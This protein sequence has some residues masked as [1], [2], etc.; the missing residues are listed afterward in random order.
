MIGVELFSGVGGMSLGAKKAGIE[1]KL[2]V[3]INSKAASTFK[4]NHK[5]TQVLNIDITDLEKINVEETGRQKVL[6]GGPP[7]QGFSLSN[8][9]TRNI[10]NPKNWLFKEFVRLAKQWKPDW[11]VVEN[12]SGILKTEKG[13]FFN[14]IINEFSSLGYKCNYKVL[15]SSNFGVP[16]KRER[17]FIVGSL[18]GINFDFPE[19]NN[20]KKI[21]VEEAIFDL[22]FLENGTSNYKLKYRCSPISDYAKELRKSSK[23]SFNNCVTKNDK[24]VIDRYMCVPQGG[25]WENIPDA[26][27]EN[28]KDHKRCHGWLYHRLDQS[29]PSIVIGNYRKNMLIHPL[30]HRGLSVREAARLQSFPDN[31]HFYGGLTEM[32]QQVANAVPPKL[33]EAVFKKIVSY[34]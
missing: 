11:I 28:Y 23:F 3:E 34:C 22:P 25:N 9:R 5:S 6:F 30:E 19:N 27:M 7:C 10:N 15:N 29:Q 1:V 17:V 33:S 26:Y 18:H 8:Q 13:I 12:V 31:F 16:Q 20:I 4:A 24:Y 32:Q 21:S 2:A 14:W